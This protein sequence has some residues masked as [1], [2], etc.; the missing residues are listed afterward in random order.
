MTFPT[1]AM[2]AISIASAGPPGTDQGSYTT[3]G[4]IFTIVACGMLAAFWLYAVGWL[5]VKRRNDDGDD[6]YGYP[7]AAPADEAPQPPPRQ[8]GSGT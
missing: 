6:G 7:E 5:I 2:V 3:G 8:L 1:A 4:I